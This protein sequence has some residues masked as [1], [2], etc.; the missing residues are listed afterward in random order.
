M[1]KVLVLAIFLSAG[2]GGQ[3]PVTAQYV[4][5]ASPDASNI[6]RYKQSITDVR[7]KFF[8]AGMSN[9]TPEQLQTFWAVYADY[10]KEKDAIAMARTDL[11]KKYV[12]AYRSEGGPQDAEL[13]QIVNDVGALQKK[14]TDLR[15]KYFAIY[16]QKLNPKAAA[17]FALID[18]YQTTAIRLNLLSQ[19][20]L[21]A[22]AAGQ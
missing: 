18:D 4:E 2:I 17:R 12:D 7:R 9:L 10:D 11:A 3:Q 13:T 5:P 20:P 8:A 14:N 19:L 22:N 16:S 1:K 21:P 6:A 15:L